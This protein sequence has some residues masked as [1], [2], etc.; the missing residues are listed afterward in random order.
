MEHLISEAEASQ[1]AAQARTTWHPTVLPS[2]Q[3][4]VRRAVTCRAA[5]VSLKSVTLPHALNSRDTA[6]V[7]KV[8]L[9]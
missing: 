8:L 5:G 3:Q 4:Q 7:K 1:L 2:S 9:P 6:A